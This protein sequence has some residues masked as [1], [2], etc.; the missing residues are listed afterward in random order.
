MDVCLS[1]CKETLFKQTR[2]VFCSWASCVFLFFFF[3]RGKC[4][5]WGSSLIYWLLRYMYVWLDRACFYEVPNLKSVSI[6]PLL[7]IYFQSYPCPQ[8]G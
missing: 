7:A 1:D 3:S 6:L 4:H 8:L 5:A 2:A